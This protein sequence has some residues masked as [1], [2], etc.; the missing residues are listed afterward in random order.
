M[1]T[2]GMIAQYIGGPEVLNQIPPDAVP[3]I[4]ILI[5]FVFS[6]FLQ[7]IVW[8][9]KKIKG[10]KNKSIQNYIESLRQ[11]LGMEKSEFLTPI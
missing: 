11:S 4:S 5:F 10:Y 8:I 1:L 2:K 6:A 7:I 9:Y 3:G